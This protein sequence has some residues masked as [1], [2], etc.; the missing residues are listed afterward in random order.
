MM[1]ALATIGLLAVAMF[2]RFSANLGYR[3]MTYPD[4]LADTLGVGAVFACIE[5]IVVVTHF[6]NSPQP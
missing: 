5:I 3:R 4:A 2:H 1:L 6:I